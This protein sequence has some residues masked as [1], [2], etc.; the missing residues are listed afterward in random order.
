VTLIEQAERLKDLTENVEAAADEER[1]A[2]AVDAVRTHVRIAR[3]AVIGYAVVPEQLQD[4]P[5]AA[6]SG[7]QDRAQRLAEVLAPLDGADDAVL[8][9]YGANEAATTT[10][11]L[12][13]IITRAK[14]LADALRSAQRHVLLTWADRLW[15]ATDLAR[16]EA[17]AAIES[18]A[19][20]LLNLRTEL[21]A[22]VGEDRPVGPA[23][24][25]RFAESVAKA[26][27]LAVDLREKAPPFAVVSFYER[28]E[29]SP[30]GVPLSQ[31]DAFVLQWL[32]E[33]AAE[34]F[35]LRRNDET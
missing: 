4:V 5:E 6:I 27:T 22:T 18:P 9:A 7:V 29:Q 32:V 13:S 15:P 14:E 20:G 24:L 25:Q 30:D 23:E 33:H 34:D 10:G 3:T 12:G 26:Q 21:L 1:A 8:V 11:V 28:L 35:R 17:L 16:L 31:I 2:R 19:K